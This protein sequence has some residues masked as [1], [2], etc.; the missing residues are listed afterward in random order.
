LRPFWK[1]FAASIAMAIMVWLTQYVFYNRLLLPAYVT[2]GDVTY[3]IGLR[4]LR[5]VRLAVQFFG[6]RYEP[7]VNLVGKIL[8]NSKNDRFAC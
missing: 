8:E 5:A 1:S 6:K 3:L 7:L 4:L 2:V